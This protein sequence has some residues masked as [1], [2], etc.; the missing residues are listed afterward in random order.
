MRTRTTHALQGT[1]C[2]PLADPLS[3]VNGFSAL[4]YTQVPLIFLYLF[5]GPS[6]HRTPQLH[7]CTDQDPCAQ[8]SVRTAHYCRHSTAY[9]CMRSP[10]HELYVEV[11]CQ[12]VHACHCIAGADTV[13]CPGQPT[14]PSAMTGR[15]SFSHSSS[16]QVSNRRVQ[17]MP[18]DHAFAHERARLIHT[19]QQ[20]PGE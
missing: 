15:G 12:C 16:A 4:L 13:A 3:G 17:K 10:V 2:T 14:T 5:S 11:L 19:L 20:C 1:L 18:R 9:M 7:T 8:H 6:L